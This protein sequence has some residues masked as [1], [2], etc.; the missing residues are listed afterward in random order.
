MSNNE[1]D[2]CDGALWYVEVTQENN[3]I[4]H[5]VDSTI[6]NYQDKQV[7]PDELGFKYHILTYKEDRTEA[8]VIRAYIG[9]VG[10]F[11]RNHARAGYNGLMV[12]NKC[13]PK[14]TVK[15]MFKKILTNWEFSDKMIRNVIKQV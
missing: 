8:E 15:E 14:K 9:D 11:I 13:I 12:K 10:F 5:E 7:E 6:Y 4:R 3:E 1:F 2:G